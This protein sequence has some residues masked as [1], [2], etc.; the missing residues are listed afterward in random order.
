MNLDDVKK[1]ISELNDNIVYDI[2][3]KFDWQIK[4]VDISVDYYESLNLSKKEFDR[5]DDLDSCIDALKAYMVQIS[6]AEGFRAT[7]LNDKAII[8]VIINNIKQSEQYKAHLSKITK[9][10][11][12]LER[13]FDTQTLEGINKYETA[14]SDY[15][16]RSCK[17]A[18]A[19]GVLQSDNFR[20]APVHDLDKDKIISSMLSD[21]VRLSTADYK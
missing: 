17:A 14:K 18:F 9:Q 4:T 11:T 15:I 10:Y 6:W 7:R 19:L 1:K 16:M 21:A 12:E 20:I 5:L 3:Y 2:I 8:D 13:S